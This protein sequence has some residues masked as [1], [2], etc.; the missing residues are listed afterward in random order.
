MGDVPFYLSKIMRLSN[1]K[2][3]PLWFSPFAFLFPE[4]VDKFPVV[5]HA[6]HA[7]EIRKDEACS[8]P[9]RRFGLTNVIA[10][11]RPLVFFRSGDY[12]HLY[13]IEVDVAGKFRRV[14]VGLNEDRLEASLEKMPGPLP[15]DVEVGGVRAVYVPHDLRQ[16]P[17]GRFQQ[18][19]IVV[20]HQAIRMDDRAVTLC[21]G[22][23]IGE[24]LLPVSSA[25]EYVFLLVA[26]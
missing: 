8:E 17:F 10:I 9:C 1:R 19:V 7:A 12:S 20:A 6:G 21:G 15:L 4:L 26:A 22:F 16:V 25:L 18:Q 24:K 13:R 11:A 2:E 23:Q 5:L 14:L 3:R